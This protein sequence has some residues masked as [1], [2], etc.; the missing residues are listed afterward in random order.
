MLLQ[1][2]KRKKQLL[3]LL[4][5]NK[6]GLVLLKQMTGTLGRRKQLPRL[7]VLRMQ[8]QAVANLA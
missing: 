8:V 6:T 3:R 5:V 1:D 7:Q 2:E 4:L